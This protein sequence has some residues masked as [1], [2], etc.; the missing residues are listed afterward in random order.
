[1]KTIYSTKYC[2]RGD[3]LMKIKNGF[4]YKEVLAYDGVVA[5]VGVAEI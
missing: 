5:V 1:M 4:S 2:L 3:G